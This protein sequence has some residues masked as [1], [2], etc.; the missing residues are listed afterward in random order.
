M[1]NCRGPLSG[2]YVS[3]QKCI[4][5]KYTRYAVLRS[6]HNCR[7]SLS[8]YYVACIIAGA[9]SHR[10]QRHRKVLWDSSPSA[11]HHCTWLT[12]ISQD[13]TVALCVCGSRNTHHLG[14]SEPGHPTRHSASHWG[15]AWTCDGERMYFAWRYVEQKVCLGWG[16]PPPPRKLGITTV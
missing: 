10:G 11:V 16:A 14:H 5:S 1:Y 3:P 4:P 15:T 9:H 2:Y 7:G 12:C 6:M 13:G 8:G